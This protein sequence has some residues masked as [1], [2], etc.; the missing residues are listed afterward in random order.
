[1]YTVHVVIQFIS[2]KIIRR[3]CDLKRGVNITYV[4]GIFTAKWWEFYADI[5][6]LRLLYLVNILVSSGL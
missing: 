1:M 2:K 6:A 5:R 3:N 4:K